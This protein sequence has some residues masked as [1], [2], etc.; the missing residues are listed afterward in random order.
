M[1]APRA[2]R[3]AHTHS[4]THTPR[5]GLLFSKCSSSAT[6]R[7]FQLNWTT[8][9]NIIEFGAFDHF[10]NW[11]FDWFDAICALG[12]IRSARF[13]RNLLSL[14]Y[15]TTGRTTFVCWFETNQPILHTKLLFTNNAYN[16]IENFQ[17][18]NRLVKNIQCVSITGY[19]RWMRNRFA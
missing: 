18:H 2:R 4:F 19:I 11:S 12:H 16:G 6:L 9:A 5:Y 13:Q 7:C 1:F 3:C 14:L 17:R 15:F 8:F 10:S